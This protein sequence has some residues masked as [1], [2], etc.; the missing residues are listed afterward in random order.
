MRDDHYHLINQGQV[1][2]DNLKYSVYR[3]SSELESLSSLS[4][5]QNK[6]ANL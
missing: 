4:E 2:E 6:V 5:F 3:S 1:N